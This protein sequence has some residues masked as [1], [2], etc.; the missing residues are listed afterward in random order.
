M[1][2]EGAI[3]AGKFRVLGTLGEGGMGTVYLVEQLSTQKRRALKLMRGALAHDPEAGERFA[4]E[5]RVGARVDSDHVVE[6]VDAGVDPVT[7]VPWLVMEHLEGET[8][9]ARIARG[10]LDP[11]T[12]AEVMRQL[13]HGL[14]AAHRAGLVHRD[15]KPENIFLAAPRREGVALTV[16]ILDLGI[17]KLVEETAGGTGSY[18]FGARATGACGTPLWMAPEQ[19]DRGVITPAADV[20]ALGLIAFQGLT[21]A[22][23]W[24]AAREASTSL[25][26]VLS[27]LT[28]EPLEPPSLRAA[29]LGR[30]EWL[31]PGFDA[32]FAGCV[33]RDPSQRFGDG[34][35]AV[36]AFLG[37][38]GHRASAPIPVAGDVGDVGTAPTLAAA[39][40][41]ETPRIVAPQTRRRRLGIGLAFVGAAVLGLGVAG[42]VAWALAPRS[43]ARVAPP[44]PTPAPPAPIFVL[45]EEAACEAGDMAACARAGVHYTEGDGVERDYAR[46]LE[47]YGRA[48]DGGAGLGCTNLGWAHEAGWGVPEDLAAAVRHYRRACDE[49][50]DP[51]GCDLLGRR[52][53]EGRG[54]PLDPQRALQLFERSCDGGEAAGCD[55][56]ARMH[57]RG[58]ATEPDLVR[59]RALY[60]RGCEGGQGESCTSLARFFA[61]GLGGP[62]DRAQARALRTR[63]CEERRFATGCN[64]LGVMF[65]DGDAGPRD[66]ARARALFEQACEGGE[67]L[68]CG[69]LG[70][71]YRDGAGGPRDPARANA[72]FLQACT[73]GLSWACEQHAG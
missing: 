67:P 37:L 22:S 53:L 70:A 19:L 41:A 5:A 36:R 56:L 72:L 39:S 73:R 68:G 28:I 49:L 9:A 38:S 15:L 17:A 44:A 13:G 35:A 57:E 59:A 43:E 71:M 65:R 25:A 31:P 66:E 24:R 45:P 34:Q 46:A 8:L 48:C 60:A 2:A 42:A 11:A 26:H 63:A 62:T 21:G 18:G 64:D 23:Y 54:V 12:F 30:A 40:L 50:G 7:S 10:E 69:N 20:W 29:E 4:R 27:E 32:W 51:G 58:I 52:H 16:K 33:S 61:E 47:L 1:L 3:F 14:G 55:E 6:V